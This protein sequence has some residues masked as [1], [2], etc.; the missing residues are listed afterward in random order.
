MDDVHNNIDDNIPRRKRK[1][2]IVFDDLIA[3]IMTNKKIQAIIKSYFSVPKEV[4]LN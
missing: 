3:Y 1:T 4:R 2:L